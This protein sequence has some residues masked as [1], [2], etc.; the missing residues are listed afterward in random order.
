MKIGNYIS[1][2]IESLIILSLFFSLCLSLVICMFIPVINREM[3]KKVKE[4][5]S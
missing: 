4:M 3:V 5:L 2:I 1:G